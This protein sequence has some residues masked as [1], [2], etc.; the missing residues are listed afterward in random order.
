MRIHDV[1]ACSQDQRCRSSALVTWEELEHP[2]GLLDFEVPVKTGRI[3]GPS[4][5]AFLLACFPLAVRHGER[6]IRID[7]PVCPMLVDGL[8]TVHAWWTD[9]GLVDTEMPVIEAETQSP[10]FD[11]PRRSMAFLSGGID[12]THMLWRNRKLYRPG[13]PAYIEDALVIQGF[14]IGKR[15]GRPEAGHFEMTLERLAPFAAEMNVNLVPC[16]SNLRHLPTEPGTWSYLHHGA[17]LAA[18][19]HA[20]V[21]GPAQLFLGASFKVANMTPWGSHPLTDVQYSSQRITLIHEG[22]RFSRLAKVGEIAESP[23]ALTSLRVCPANAPGQLNCG[24]CEKCIRTRL[25]LL[26]SG[27]DHS[28]AFGPSA[29]PADLLE[30]NL[31]IQSAY[32]RSYY[33]DLLA[34]LDA[35]GFHQLSRIV[36]SKLEGQRWAVAA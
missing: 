36:A 4:A 3:A 20:A 19:A 29:V 32:Q 24:E 8:H 7:S 35:R 21:T 15:K 12:S 2:D 16:S 13:D 34:P 1:E 30:R 22:S 5:E 23:V 17:A 31:E 18:V 11:T 14:D 10:P 25:E 9:W 28:A 26:A 6:R 27:H 33:E